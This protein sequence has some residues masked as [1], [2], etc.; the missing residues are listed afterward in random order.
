[1]LYW[2]GVKITRFPSNT[3][4]GRTEHLT[5]VVVRSAGSKFASARVAQV[6]VTAWMQAWLKWRHDRTSNLRRREPNWSVCRQAAAHRRREWFCPGLAHP[7][8]AQCSRFPLLW[9]VSIE[10]G[11]LAS[12]I[13]SPTYC[14]V[15]NCGL[16]QQKWSNIY[17]EVYVIKCTTCWN[18]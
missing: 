11:L 13:V 2:N 16:S 18:S 4:A 10:C 14:N 12:R 8:G 5:V 7:L 1:M 15:D 17:R 6:S 9:E 3:W